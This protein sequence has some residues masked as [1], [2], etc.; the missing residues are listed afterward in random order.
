MSRDLSI[1]RTPP[2]RR[3]D[4]GPSL[5]AARTA[6]AQADESAGFDQWRL[7]EASRVLRFQ[8]T[9]SI[10]LDNRANCFSV[11]W[12]VV[13][14]AYLRQQP[15]PVEI[16]LNARQVRGRTSR[17]LSAIASAVA[18][19]GGLHF[20]PAHQLQALEERSGPGR[21]TAREAMG[22]GRERGG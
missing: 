4:G 14:N 21:G 3:E 22:S 5:V 12:P 7:A 16:L 15:K 20:P 1:P 9:E 13:F 8:L 19:V 17:S 6:L 2:R 10:Y 18:L 11:T